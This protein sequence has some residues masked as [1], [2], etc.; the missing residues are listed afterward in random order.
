MRCPWAA[1]QLAIVLASVATI[2]N[3]PALLLVSGVL[4]AVGAV[5]TANG[6]F[7]VL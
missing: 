6:Y 2:I 3:G 7:L 4:A 5:V 1:L